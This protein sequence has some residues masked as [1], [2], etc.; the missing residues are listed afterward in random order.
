MDFPKV[1]QIGRAT[2]SGLWTIR[3]NSTSAFLVYSFPKRNLVVW[4]LDYTFN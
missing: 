2:S 1:W 4:L 3:P